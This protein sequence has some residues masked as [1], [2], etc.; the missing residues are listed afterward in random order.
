MLN[1]KASGT[2]PNS[3]YYVK[4]GQ[5]VL[6]AFKSVNWAD[7]GNDVMGARSISQ[8]DIITAAENQLK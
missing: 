7:L 1:E 5:N 3:F 4:G 6:Q 2:N 8:A